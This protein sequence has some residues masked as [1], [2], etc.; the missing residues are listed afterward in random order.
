[1]A[2]FSP[3]Q[4]PDPREKMI[5]AIVLGLRDYMR[6]NGFSDVVLGISG[7]LDSALVAALAVRALGPEHVH[8]VALPS[9]YNASIS[10]EDAIKLGANLGMD[11]RT[12][13]IEKPRQVFD[14]LLAETFKDCR[15]DTTEENLQARIRANI[16]MALSNKFGWILLCTGN[17][18]ETACGY[19]TLY[20]DGAGGIAPI[21]DVYK[22]EAFELCRY[23]NR[24]KEIIP[25]RIITRPPSA[26]LRPDQKDADSLPE[27]EVLDG[28]LRLYLEQLYSASQIIEQ[29]YDEATVKRVV[30]LVRINEF[31][32]KQGP[33][34]LRLSTTLFGCDYDMPITDRFSEQ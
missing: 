5:Q 33:L 27:Y 22:T 34:G 17:K 21:K 9:C 30:R 15:P 16:L 31:K 7:G 6:K 24:E 25:E 13:S 12:I 2:A 29:G 19:S 10:L 3:Y 18:S 11:M 8:G 14:E 20:G 23:I 4:D 32:R 28:I 1:L 26:E